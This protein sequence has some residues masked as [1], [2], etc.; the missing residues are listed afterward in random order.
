MNV[1]G[2]GRVIGESVAL[3]LVRT[4]LD[5]KD[6]DED[7]HQRRLE[8]VKAIEGRCQIQKDTMN[9]PARLPS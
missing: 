2:W 9:C 7:R 1:L 3:E 8:K 4:F 5:S 6:T